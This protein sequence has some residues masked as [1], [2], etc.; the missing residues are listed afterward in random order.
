MA[1]DIAQEL[2]VEQL[3]STLNKKLFLELT[4]VQSKMP[5][6]SRTSVPTLAAEVRSGEIKTHPRALTRYFWVDALER[7]TKGV[8]HEAI[9]LRNALQPVN[10]LYSEVIALCAAFDEGRKEKTRRSG[11]RVGSM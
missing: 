6:V 3:I 5:P 1:F 9:S 4:N 2:S 10:G 8:L 11:R 7:R